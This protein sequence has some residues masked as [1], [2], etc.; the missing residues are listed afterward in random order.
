FSTKASSVYNTTENL[1]PEYVT[2][3][4]DG[5]GCFFIGISPDPR[6]KTG[7]RIKATFQIGVHEKDLAL[8]KQI[9][10]FFGV[11]HVTKLGVESVQYRVS[12]LNDLNLIINHF[13]KY[14][15]L[16]RKQSDFLLFK[17]VINLM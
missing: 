1:N 11:R 3:F 17:E 9:E 14:P 7:Y 16:T 10:L 6:Y 8:L 5:E 2:G 4:T 13:D 12:G 15:L